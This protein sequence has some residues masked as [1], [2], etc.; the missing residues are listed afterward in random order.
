MD[1]HA[2]AQRI[3]RAMRSLSVV[4]AG[5]EHKG[6]FDATVDEN[7]HVTLNFGGKKAKPTMK[8]LKAVANNK[9]PWPTAE[10]RGKQ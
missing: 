10:A 4:V 2:D 7:G 3:F 8:A 1:P 6:P 5:K 9:E